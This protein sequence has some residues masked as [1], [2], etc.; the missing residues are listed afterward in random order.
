[1][2]VGITVMPEQGGQGGHWL[3][4]YLSD[5][6]TLFQPGRADYRGDNLPCY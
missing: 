3:P 2:T 5:Q 1:M 4:R 6:L